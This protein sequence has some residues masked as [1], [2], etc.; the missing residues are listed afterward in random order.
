MTTRHHYDNHDWYPAVRRVD[1]E[2]ACNQQTV[3]WHCSLPVHQGETVGGRSGQ[4]D[5]PQRP[6]TGHD[7]HHS[8]CKPPLHSFGDI[9][10]IF[11]RKRGSK[12]EG[13]VCLG[14][15]MGYGGVG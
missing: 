7:C 8:N 14:G 10:C 12:L 15:W 5:L 4:I 1:P 9:G 13:W 2:P 11:Y 6:F 3:T